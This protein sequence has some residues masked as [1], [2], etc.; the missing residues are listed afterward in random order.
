MS[1]PQPI[2]VSAC[3]L[4]AAAWVVWSLSGQRTRLLLLR[5]LCRLLPALQGPLGRLQRQLDAP[6]GCT[7]CRAPRR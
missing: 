7:A 1:S 4:L 3:V 6:S 5:A 2:I